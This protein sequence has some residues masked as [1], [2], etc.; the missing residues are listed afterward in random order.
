MER[1][2]T[3]PPPLNDE[4]LDDAST[5]IQSAAR[6]HWTRQQAAKKTKMSDS[7]HWER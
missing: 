4:E 1:D 7:K 5:I 6:A 2:Q 3:P